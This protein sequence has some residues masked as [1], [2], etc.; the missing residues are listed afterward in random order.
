MYISCLPSKEEYYPGDLFESEITVKNIAK[1]PIEVDLISA[2]LHGDY[3]LT[4]EVE[5]SLNYQTIKRPPIRT[6]LPDV[7]DLGFIL[8]IQRS[9]FIY[10]YN[11]IILSQQEHVDFHYMHL[12]QPS[13]NA[14]INFYQMMKENV[15]IINQFLFLCNF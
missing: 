2:Q 15:F 1:V 6:S 3:Y 5:S 8:I 14:I 12:K 10:F 9:F 13:L 4:N 7:V 11:L